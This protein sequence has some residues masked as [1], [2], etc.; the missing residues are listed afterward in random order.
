MVDVYK[1]VID[2]NKVGFVPDKH[3][4]GRTVSVNISFADLPAVKAL[5]VYDI[6]YD[7]TK[8]ELVKGKWSTEDAV[9]NNFDEALLMGELAFTE[10]TSMKDVTLTLTFKVL[11]EKQ[12]EVIKIDCKTVVKR[13]VD[14]VE[15]YVDTVV[16]SGSVKTLLRGDMDN[17]G[18]VDSNDAIYLLR[19]T[20]LPTQY[21]ITQDG[22][23]DGNGKTDSNDAIY[24]LRYTLEPKKYPLHPLT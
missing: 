15:T 13:V 21:P 1:V 19:Y 7:K 17:N 12:N 4:A 16:I 23:M 24:L 22:D 9:I 14:N 10:N 5:G 3:N 2:E 18:K 8:L 6:T 11:T 20:L